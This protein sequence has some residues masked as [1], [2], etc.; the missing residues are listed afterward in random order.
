[1]REISLSCFAYRLR[2][3][4]HCDQVLP[5]L[6]L[7]SCPAETCQTHAVLFLACLWREPSP[8]TKTPL[9]REAPIF[10]LVPAKLCRLCALQTARWFGHGN[11]WIY[12]TQ[13][14]IAVLTWSI[15]SWFCLFSAPNVLISYSHLFHPLHF[16]ARKSFAV[17]VAALLFPKATEVCFLQCLLLSGPCC[18][19]E[20]LNGTAAE[21]T[22]LCHFI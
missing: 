21:L 13:E 12:Y 1:M 6:F 2:V 17:S 9:D 16:P 22:A 18:V 20:L 5:A 10:R 3:S 15:M 8:P 4:V 7:M 14:W 11:E 19:S